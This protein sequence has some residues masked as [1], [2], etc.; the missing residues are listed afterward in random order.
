MERE[1]LPVRVFLNLVNFCFFRNNKTNLN[2]TATAG[3]YPSVVMYDGGCLLCRSE[4]QYLKQRDRQGRLLL[5]DISDPDFDAG[6]W[7][8]RQ[9]ALTDALHVLTGEG[10]WLIGMPAVRHVYAR[11]GLGWLLAPTSWP[12]FSGL[13]DLAYRYTAQH[14][15]LLSRWLGMGG[16]HA[17]CAEQACDP[18]QQQTRRPL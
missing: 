17:A 5:V 15:A 12:L 11:V 7:G 1:R 13:S 8:F 3:T 10:E 9:A 18:R 4:M 14:R 16:T 6:I 2:D